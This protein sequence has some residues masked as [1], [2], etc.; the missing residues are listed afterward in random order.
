M[1]W[2]R[3]DNNKILRLFNRFYQLNML[4]Y[5]RLWRDHCQTWVNRNSTQRLCNGLPEMLNALDCN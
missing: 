5:S 3:A 4:F 1:P 2:G